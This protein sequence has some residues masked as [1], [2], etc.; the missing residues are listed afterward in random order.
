MV[1]DPLTPA[2]QGG[3][4]QEIARLRLGCGWGLRGSLGDLPPRRDVFFVGL[5]DVLMGVHNQGT[6]MGTVSGD[7][8]PR[9]PAVDGASA[10]GLG[11]RG[12][13]PWPGQ[14]AG[15]LTSG[16]PVAG[17]RVE[18]TLIELGCR[19]EGTTVCAG[20][21]DLRGVGFRPPL[22][23]ETAHRAGA[24][25]DHALAGE[26]R[27]PRP[28]LVGVVC[29]RAWLTCRDA[30]AF[31]AAAAQRGV[32]EAGVFPFRPAV[33]VVRP[34]PPRPPA[35]HAACSHGRGHTRNGH[36]PHRRDASSPK[37]TVGCP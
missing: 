6:H 32:E 35:S 4:L 12:V 18:C 13:S 36:E 24:A 9:L 5:R 19:A 1:T 28:V 20:G 16:G 10:G 30:A 25:F 3:C 15:A 31:L 17:F 14:L 23:D 7:D 34:D 2:L 33:L 26:A 27:F 29:L 21:A 11:R 22:A 8:A 37:S